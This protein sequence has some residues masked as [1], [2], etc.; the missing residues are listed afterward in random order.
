MKKSRKYEGA[1]ANVE[2][3]ERSIVGIAGIDNVAL[4]QIALTKNGHL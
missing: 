4:E 3:L 1:N 2:R